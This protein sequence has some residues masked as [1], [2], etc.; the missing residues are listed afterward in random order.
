MHVI[1]LLVVLSPSLGAPRIVGHGLDQDG[2]SSEPRR[3]ESSVDASDNTENVLN[4][5]NNVKQNDKN[6]PNK[7]MTNFNRIFI[8]IF[9]LS[10]DELYNVNSTNEFDCNIDNSCGQWIWIFKAIGCICIVILVLYMWQWPKPEIFTVDFYCNLC[11]P[12]YAE[13]QNCCNT[14][15]NTD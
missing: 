3:S 13:N 15:I 5:T 12:D 2:K 10:F 7:N 6:T 14:R 8:G 11:C 4:G 1:L 9:V